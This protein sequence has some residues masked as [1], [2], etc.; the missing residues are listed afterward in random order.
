MAQGKRNDP[1]LEPTEVDKAYA[2]GFI[3]GEG[4]IY[5]RN[6]AARPDH[7][8]RGWRTSAY[9]LL[10]V[11]QV[12]PRTLQW[13]QVRWGGAIRQVKR[14]S[15]KR[16]NDRDAWEWNCSARQAYKLLHDVLPFL[17]DKRPQAVN[18]LRLEAMK[19]ARGQT[20]WS[21]PVSEE[22]L[23][24]QAEITAEARRLNQLRPEWHEL[25]GAF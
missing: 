9:A 14:R 20:G 17:R 8:A 3:D 4:T 16:P 1:V 23:S 7:R 22:G 25:P 5:V 11:P 21:R 13:M 2:A 6:Q 10:V 15:E 24:M 19:R 12:D 18:A